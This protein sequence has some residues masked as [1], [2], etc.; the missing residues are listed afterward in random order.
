M[1]Q[2]IKLTIAYD[3]TRY[4]GWQIQPNA[5]SIQDHIQK[6]LATLLKEPVLVIGSGRTDAGVHA[7]GQVAH[8]VAPTTLNLYRLQHSLNALLPQDIR[9]KK[10]EIAPE[11]F[12]SRF[13]AKSKIYHYY[14]HLNPVKNPFTKL[15][16]LYVPYKVDLSLLKLGTEHFIGTHNFMSFTNEVR[17]DQD[18]VRTI[19]RLDMVQTDDGVRLEF[20]G[21]GFLY[22]MVRNIVGTLLDVARKK[23]TPDAIKTIL[24]AQDRKMGCSAVPPQGLFLVEVFY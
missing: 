12:H 3:G 6:E 17:D 10:M 7:L 22:K 11:D 5:P 15:Y 16:S 21:D 1:Q 18:C 13:S 19:Y 2:K 9:I 23:I 4:G 24:A 8:F 20:E 14:L